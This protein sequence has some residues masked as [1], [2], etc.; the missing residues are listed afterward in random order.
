MSLVR[1][2]RSW[3]YGYG[4]H[5]TMFSCCSKAWKIMAQSWGHTLL[6][7]SSLELPENAPR[8]TWGVNCMRDPASRGL[9]ASRPDTAFQSVEPTLQ[10][11][12]ERR[13]FSV[14]ERAERGEGAEVD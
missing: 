13:S 3:L 6:V 4:T 14:V 12:C 8:L 11:A 7:S 10:T 1:T 5:T 9:E 2:V